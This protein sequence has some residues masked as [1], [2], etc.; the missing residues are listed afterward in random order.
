[1]SHSPEDVLFGFPLQK[2]ALFFRQLATMVD[3]GLPIASAT[4]T[5]GRQTAPKVTRRLTKLISEGHP[6]S[7]AMKAFPYFF[8]DYEINM[9]LSG[10]QSG[11]LDGQLNELAASMEWS[12]NLRKKL[13]SRLAYPVLVLHAAVFIPPLFLLI[14][15]GLKAYVTVT[16]SI[17]IPAYLVAAGLWL[18]YRM[19]TMGSALR[20]MLDSF[21]A[22]FPILG[23][24]FRT[25]A[26]M[27]FL[28]ALG[29]MNHAGMLPDKAIPLAANACGNRAIAVSILNANKRLGVGHSISENLAASRVFKPIEISMV[30]TGEESGNVASL[31]LKAAEHL[32]LEY[33][34]ETHKLMT[35]LPVL[36][37][38]GVG[39]IVLGVCVY[40]MTGVI[41]P[42]TNI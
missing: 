8:D 28:D 35:I 3:A 33:E 34:S 20:L 15:Q 21:L 23:A 36:L 31:I 18:A 39:G 11:D 5:A 40:M 13:M 25:A 42:L 29:K 6:L 32:R 12:Y 7:G 41:A 38:M 24:P 16:M 10:E 26:K 9:V 1:M 17:V 37:L 22:N 4:E 2:K 19:C 30:A 27:R 14:T